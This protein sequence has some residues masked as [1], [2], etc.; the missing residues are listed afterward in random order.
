[1]KA[2]FFHENMQTSF[3]ND[4]NKSISQKYPLENPNYIGDSAHDNKKKNK[5]KKIV[6]KVDEDLSTLGWLS[7][8]YLSGFILKQFI[9]FIKNRFKKHLESKETFY[10][11]FELIEKTDSSFQVIE[12]DDRYFITT[13]DKEL[14][15]EIGPIKIFKNKKM[16]AVLDH[17]L[18]LTSSEHKK[19]LD[20]IKEKI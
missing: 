2:K 1:M 12:Y 18:L 20:I 10:D 13:T 3:R 4:G 6:K 16:M 7:V 15:E 19:I 5:F 8:G 9:N 11:L 17:Y 14:N